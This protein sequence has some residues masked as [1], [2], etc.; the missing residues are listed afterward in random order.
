MIYNI[1]HR[2]AQ[3]SKYSIFLEQQRT[4]HELGIKTT[5]F[6]HYKDLFN[7]T[8]LESITRD[9][10]EFG[11]EVGLALHDMS[12]PGMEGLV[13]DLP[14]IWLFDKAKKREI[15]QK[16][17]AKYIEVFGSAPTSVASYHFDSSALRI[18]KE[19][20]PQCETVVGGCFEEGVRVFHGCN[21]SWYL[22]NEGMPWGPW[23]PSKTHSLRPAVDEADSAGVVAVPH[24]V[25]D[26]SL[27]YEGRNDFW[28][29]HPPNVVRGMG[30]DASF[31]PYDLNLID[32]YRLQEEYNGRQSYLNT[33]VGVNWLTWNHNSEY[34]PEV[35]WEL[36]RK[37]LR[38]LVELREQGEA[39]D[40]YLS[41]Y[42]RWFRKNR[43]YGEVEV[44]HAKEMLY[45]SGKHY[46]WYLDGE[47][48]LLIDPAQG[49]S[50]G[51]I[52]SYVGRYSA[53]T[54]PDTPNREIG[55]YPYIIQSQHRT[56]FA[57]HHEDGARTSCFIEFGEESVDLASIRTKVA[58]VEKTDH[59]T[60][61]KLT[62]AEF[63]FPSGLTGKLITSYTLQH[64]AASTRITR[65]IE[66]LSSAEATLTITEHFKGAPGKTEYA[67]DLRDIIL[68]ANGPAATKIHYDYAGVPTQ[69]NGATQ[70]SASIPQVNTEVSLN[71]ADDSVIGGVLKCGNLFSP[72]FTLQLKHKLV[73]NGCVRST[74]K[75]NKIES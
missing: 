37:M 58:S 8:L 44:Y 3:G 30:N 63:R 74:L 66:N 72:Y 42:G 10:R 27:S 29:S 9:A 51:D 23:Y 28:A 36:Y 26:M 52:R 11:D 64:N 2:A 4:V 25:R 50:I 40:M 69:V 16:I 62:P 53:E 1:M 32:Q 59:V 75:L 54:G 47:Q 68:T 13:G 65:T 24:L 15:I 20:C 56:G 35:C 55:T 61:L 41:E 12:G 21:H 45:G 14:A 39:E 48:R 17:L 38:Y 22:F 71:S 57:H 73:G 34:P 70:V 46:F 7:E 60:T 43:Q 49:G 67:D 33:F 18:L 31:N 6:V 19:L 5:V